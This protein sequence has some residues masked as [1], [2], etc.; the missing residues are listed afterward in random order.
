MFETPGSRAV[1]DLLVKHNNLND[2]VD[3]GVNGDDNHPD[4]DDLM[5][6]IMITMKLTRKNDNQ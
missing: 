3:C 4:I 2:F 1:G 5:M 6:A